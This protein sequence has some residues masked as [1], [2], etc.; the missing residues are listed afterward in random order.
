MKERILPII[1]FGFIINQAYAFPTVNLT[2]N[3][4]P[5][6]YASFE[7]SCSIEDYQLNLKQPFELHFRR[8]GQNIAEYYVYGELVVPN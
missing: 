6:H 7:I 3:A 4:T 2:T 5:G 1:L 8:N